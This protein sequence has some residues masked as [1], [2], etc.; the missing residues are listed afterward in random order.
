MY[1]VWQSAFALGLLFSVFVVPGAAATLL[2]L[3]FFSLHAEV[4]GYD[5]T[6]ADRHTQ[7][8]THYIG[9]IIVSNDTEYT[10]CVDTRVT[11]TESKR[12]QI[13][14]PIQCSGP[15]SMRIVDTAVGELFS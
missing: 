13:L 15:T 12:M 10:V 11:Y 8:G 6:L 7:D 9:T 1:K 2:D 4:D 14:G 3:G 5:V